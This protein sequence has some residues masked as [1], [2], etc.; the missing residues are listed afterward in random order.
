MKQPEVAVE[1]FKAGT[2]PFPVSASLSIHPSNGSK[3]AN[4]TDKSNFLLS[5]MDGI[6]HPVGSSLHRLSCCIRG[7]AR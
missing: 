7:A 1:K 3:I 5:N 6:N 2:V 4:E